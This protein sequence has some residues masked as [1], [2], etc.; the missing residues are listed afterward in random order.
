MIG[1]HTPRPTER[2]LLGAILAL[3][4][5]LGLILGA[6]GWYI[7]MQLDRVQRATESTLF[8]GI[9]GELTASYSSLNG[10]LGNERKRFRALHRF[11]A[12]YFATHGRDADL[13]PLKRELEK[14]AG[15]PVDVYVIDPD[16]TVQRS[17]YAPDRGLSFNQPALKDA[18][19][20][21]RKAQRTGNIMV[22]PPVL[23]LTTRKF[24]IYTYSAF[25]DHGY[26]LEL[27]FVPPAV[28]R[29]FARAVKRLHSRDAY[30]AE[31][32]FLMW[33]E[34]TLSLNG[35]STLGTDKQNQID[36]EY[37]TNKSRTA[38]FRQAK[39][40]NTP[41]RRTEADGTPVYY[42]PLLSLNEE[43]APSM[44]VMARVEM[45]LQAMG[46][47]RSALGKA[48][49]VLSALILT[50]VLLL[51]VALRRGVIRPLQKA[52]TAIENWQTIDL[53]PTASRVSELQLLASRYN[54]M[55]GDARNQI[56]GLDRKANTDSLTGLLNRH[57]LEQEV[58]TELKRLPRADAE[59]AI[60]ML[61]IDHFKRINDA[62]GHL[63]GDEVLRRLAALLRE[64]T[65]SSDSIGRWG[66][67]EFLIVCRDTDLDGAVH[68]AETLRRRVSEMNLRA[69]RRIT[70]SFGV[71]ASRPGDD[72]EAVFSRADK[73]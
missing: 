53:G 40:S 43:G 57:R 73:A 42:L 37:V 14:A 39:E 30:N 21:V 59:L 29:F 51:Y 4:T 1:R 11:A 17:T 63:E 25:G 32:Y 72:F 27:G 66:G 61:D 58:E 36:A 55:L 23:E 44:D 20:F 65:R 49:I 62:R 19:M 33:N 2:L 69:D 9:R 64:H 54:A 38:L 48:L 22:E 60:V 35:D 10:L 16:R 26:T 71:T 50:A 18:Q 70:C 3:L 24:R 12:D 47:S 13:E 56:D 31:L 5:T 34:L 28:N 46:E 41:L 7:E 15:M 45:N 52:A 6:F 8:E 67:E 68:L